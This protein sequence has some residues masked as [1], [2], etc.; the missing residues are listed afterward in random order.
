M[1]YFEHQCKIN[2]KLA[3]VLFLSNKMTFGFVFEDFAHGEMA[4]GK[5]KTLLDLSYESFIFA[6]II[7]HPGRGAWH[8]TVSL[9]SYVTEMLRYY[10]LC[11]Y[12]CTVPE[13][14]G[15]HM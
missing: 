2:K 8:L 3:T 7:Y 13:Y 5:Y 12:R 1:T 15:I 10:N 9:C 4:N 11:T 14:T 6:E